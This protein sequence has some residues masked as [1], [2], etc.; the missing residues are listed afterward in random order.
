MTVELPNGVYVKFR[1]SSVVAAVPS[2]RGFV[3]EG[4]NQ[5][6]VSVPAFW[7]ATKPVRGVPE[8]ES[9]RLWPHTEPVRLDPDLDP[10]D[11]RPML[12]IEDIDLIVV[13][14]RQP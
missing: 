3:P 4:S 9:P 14:S 7:F 10:G 2:L 12:G 6:I 8:R 1:L 5:R 11:Q 13:A